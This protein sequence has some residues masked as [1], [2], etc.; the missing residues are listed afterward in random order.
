[1]ITETRTLRSTEEQ[2]ALVNKITKLKE[3]GKTTEAACAELDTT[4]VYYYTAR[5][6]LG[7]SKRREHTSSSAS[8]AIRFE[9]VDTT[10][11]APY[12]IDGRGGRFSQFRAELA[13]QLAALP[14]GKSVTFYPPRGADDKEIK[15]ILTAAKG[16]IRENKLNAIARY[17]EALGKFVI[18]P[19][20]V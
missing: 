8:T 17:A 15:A 9:E 20:G 6:R 5:K 11:V 19:K 10:E 16:A 14:R 4:P 3:E 18:M 12:I 7:L 13:Q 1:M 2:L